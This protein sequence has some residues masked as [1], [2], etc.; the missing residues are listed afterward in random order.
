[1]IHAPKFIR[2]ANQWLVHQIN[3]G[4]DK[5]EIHKRNWFDTKEAAL[6]FYTENAK[7]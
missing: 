3:I 5:K 7:N 6:Q 4:N 1:M 2:K